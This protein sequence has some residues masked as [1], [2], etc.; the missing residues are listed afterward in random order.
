MAGAVPYWAAGGMATIVGLLLVEVEAEEGMEVV[1][2]VVACLC[3]CTAV[4]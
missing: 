1:F 2:A 3:G 4:M